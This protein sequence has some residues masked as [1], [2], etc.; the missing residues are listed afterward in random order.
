M[1]KNAPKNI[2]R[3]QIFPINEKGNSRHLNVIHVRGNL[4]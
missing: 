2:F 4:Y 3:G 1:P